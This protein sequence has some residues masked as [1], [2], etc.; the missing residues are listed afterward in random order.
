M[1]CNEHTER[2]Q[3]LE[4]LVFKGR[5]IGKRKGR[6]GLIYI[7]EQDAHPTRVAYKTIK[8]FERNPS[9]ED[10]PIGCERI[11]RETRNWFQFAGHPLVIKPQFVR[12]WDGFPLICMPY[13]DGDLRDLVGKEL[14]LTGV[15]CLSLQIVKGMIVANGRGMDHHQDV[16]P[17]NLLYID[18]SKKFD[19]FPPPGIDPS[20]KYSVR[21]ADFGVANAWHEKYP[22]GTNAYKA[23]EQHEYKTEQDAKLYRDAFNPDIFGVGLVIAELFQGYHP[24]TEGPNPDLWKSKGSKLKKWTIEGKR[25]FAPAKDS[26]AEELLRL[27]EQMLS[28]DPTMRPT[29]HYCF[30]RLANILKVLSPSTLEYLEFIFE[31]FDYTST[32]CELEDKMDRY[33]KLSVMP[34]QR[35]FVQEKI[36]KLL[37]DALC[38]DLVTLESALRVHHLSKA[39]HRMC[40]ND[41]SI[42]QDKTLLVEASKLVVKFAIENHKSI[43]ADCLW[44]SFSFR[45]PKPKKLATDIEAKAEILNTSVERLQ[46]FDAYDKQ[47]KAQVEEGSR[48]IQACRVLSDAQRAWRS[49][50]VAEACDLLDEVR[51]LVPYEPELESLYASWKSARNLF[52]DTTSPQTTA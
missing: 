16:K 8:E 48:V 47:L 52:A 41:C 31:Y 51:Q 44:P 46:L 13:C 30:N 50:Q 33:L 20:V 49:G 11:G 21:I 5:I 4:Q 45:D 15:V 26:Q 43:T 36:R 9:V 10:Q 27:V 29:F 25:H 17:E 6:G 35:E 23:P 24:A 37:S 38:G 40:I 2:M 28:A 39:L 7:V 32:Y 12:F 22:G 19:D 42:L 1:T 14:S 34:G 3:L 18:L